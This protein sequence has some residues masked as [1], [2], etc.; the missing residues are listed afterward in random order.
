MVPSPRWLTG[1]VGIP[2]Y[3][4]SVFARRLCDLVNAGANAEMS[5]SVSTCQHHLTMGWTASTT[6][7][8]IWTRSTTRGWRT[9]GEGPTLL[10][11]RRVWAVQLTVAALL[12]YTY[13]RT[14]VACARGTHQ[15]VQRSHPVIAAWHVSRLIG[16]RHDKRCLVFEEVRD[17]RYVLLL[18]SQVCTLGT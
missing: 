5:S 3:G 9:G 4:K 6:R 8:H 15:C 12:C 10:D 2:L 18:V 17:V 14:S 16:H 11:L 1:L 13:V 7:A